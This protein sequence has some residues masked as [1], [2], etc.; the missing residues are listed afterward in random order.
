MWSFA[1]DRLVTIA[2]KL[3]QSSGLDALRIPA[4]VNGFFLPTKLPGQE[5]PSRG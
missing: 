3:A 1:A 5:L 2:D 4:P